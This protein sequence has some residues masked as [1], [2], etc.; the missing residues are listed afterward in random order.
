[1]KIWWIIALGLLAGCAGKATWA[2][3]WA[4][5]APEEIPVEVK[6]KDKQTKVYISPTMRPRPGRPMALVRCYRNAKAETIRC[7][8][9]LQVHSQAPLGERKISY[10]LGGEQR[11]GALNLVTEDRACGM[12]CDEFNSCAHTCY[13]VYLMTHN[14]E[15]GAVELLR[16]MA[17][18]PADL[19]EPLE[20]TLEGKGRLVKGAIA[21]SALEAL[22]V[23]M[24][25]EQ[26]AQKAGAA[27]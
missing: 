22:F 9:F 17:A 25:R 20:F 10:K 21:P 13:N 1:M 19:R 3:D 27:P 16:R 15:P 2:G 24:G 23:E 26:E 11:L 7:Q 5:R 4:Q 6:Q 8:L 12:L 18:M 14:L